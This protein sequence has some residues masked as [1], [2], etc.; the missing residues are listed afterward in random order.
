MVLCMLRHRHCLTRLN[1]HQRMCLAFLVN[2]RLL[3][4]QEVGSCS[5]L[6]DF[7]VIIILLLLYHLV[8]CNET[9]HLTRTSLLK[10]MRYKV[11]ASVQGFNLRA[12]LVLWERM[13]AVYS[14][15]RVGET[16][17]R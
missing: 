1:H 10:D 15:E 5:E 17:D 3:R 9:L 11:Q 14:S 6:T 16:V 7:I 13:H 4:W 8:Y 2:F 12:I